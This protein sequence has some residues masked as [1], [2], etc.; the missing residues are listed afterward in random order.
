MT[1]R[2]SIIIPA[3]NEEKTLKE[4]LNRIAQVDL[5]ALEKEVIAV[6][7]GSRDATDRALA[8]AAHN[9]PLCLILISH[10]RNRGK[11][12]AIKTGLSACTGDYILIQ[13]AD[14]ECDP[15]D[16]PALL[17]PIL[18]KRTDSVAGSRILHK[19]NA[20]R[21]AL[22]HYGGMFLSACFNAFFKTSLTDITGC[23]K[24]FPRRM[25]PAIRALPS[26]DFVFDAVELPYTLARSGTIEE[27]PVRY[28]PRGR[29]QG[30][31]LHWMHGVKCLPAMIRLKLR[32]R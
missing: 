31:K 4:V 17:R 12:A 6:N 30:K 18:E 9:T 25:V 5:G 7:D 19:E 15:N 2:L 26:D 32:K 24:V 23:Y 10:A 29:A 27:I 8:D 14:D 16:Y 11:G 28:T 21:S 3:Y 22:Y 1:P 13:D 20:P